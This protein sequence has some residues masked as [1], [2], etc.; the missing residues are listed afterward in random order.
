M[1]RKMLLSAALILAVTS[2]ANG[3]PQ[4][5]DEALAA[6]RPV[7][8]EWSR[9]CPDARIGAGEIREALLTPTMNVVIVALG[10]RGAGGCFG[11][12]EPTYAMVKVRGKW[13]DLNVGGAR[14]EPL[15]PGQRAATIVEPV[16][17]TCHITYTW[18]GKS[19][20]A[21]RTKGCI[22]D[23]ALANNK[24]H[25]LT[26]AVLAEI[27]DSV[28]RSGQA[29]AAPSKQVGK[30]D[31]LQAGSEAHAAAPALVQNKGTYCACEIS[32]ILSPAPNVA[33]A[34]I[35]RCHLA[36]AGKA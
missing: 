3:A 17:G 31:A 11:N 2:V 30:A 23:Q 12:T 7:M 21:S 32:G 9:N 35:L 28:G 16:R 29:N 34:Q 19:Y 26:T 18:G 5:R 4:D 27:A 20:T 25:L 6:L 14:I 10:G 33:E 24:A 13:R 15:A 8:A 36:S 22:V 1:I